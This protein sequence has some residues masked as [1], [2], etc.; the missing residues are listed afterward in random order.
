MERYKVKTGKQLELLE[1]PVGVNQP[2]KRVNIVRLKMIK[3]G[4]L[5]YKER[6]IKSPEE[7]SLLLKQFLGEVDR[8]Y[9]IVLCLDTKNQTTTKNVCHIGSLNASIVHPRDIKTFILISVFC[10]V[11]YFN[12]MYSM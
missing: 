2:A 1:T 7:A 4:S 9:F 10:K 8:E 5:L 12:Y 6:R 11:F 3:E